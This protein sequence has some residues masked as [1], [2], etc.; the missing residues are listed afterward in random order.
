L[1]A[2]ALL[3]STHPTVFDYI[4]LVTSVTAALG[5]IGFTFHKA[6]A[7]EAFWRIAFPALAV[8][9]VTYNVLISQVLGLAQHGIEGDVVAWLAGPRSSVSRLWPLP[10]CI[11]AT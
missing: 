1:S 8:W 4:D 11:P 2:P 7:T 6:I 9:E 10:L 3:M 5:L